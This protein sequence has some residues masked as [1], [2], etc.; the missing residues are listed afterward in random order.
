MTKLLVIGLDAATWRIIKPNLGQLPYFKK[1]INEGKYKTIIAKDA[2]L[3]PAIWCTIFSGKT[4]AEHGHKKYVVDDKLQSRK[5]IK[6]K[7]I[8]DILNNK[9]DIRALQVPFVIPPYNFNCEHEAIGHGASYD[10]NEL[11][12]DADKLV[13]RALKILKQYPDIFIVVFNQLDRMQHFHWGEPT[14]LSWYKKIDQYLGMLTKYGE[15][16]IIVSDH[17]FCSKGEAEIKTLPDKN[18]KGEELKGDHHEEAILITKNISHSINQHK[19]I[20]NAIL[21]ETDY[22]R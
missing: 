7:F 21:N 12:E 8:W 5:D 11:E 14:V 19:D 13:F 4:L 9:C 3:S 20:F 10:L 22:A 15:K 18:D 2:I 17:G 6:V 1:L 16:L